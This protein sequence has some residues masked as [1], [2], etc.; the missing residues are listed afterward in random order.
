MAP[1]NLFD[2]TGIVALVTG[3]NGGLGRSMALG[4]ANAGAAV[5]IFGRNEK[6]NQAVLAELKAAG[7]RALALR[8]DMTKDSERDA[9]FAQVENTLGPVHVLVNNAGLGV[10]KPALAETR[11]GWLETLDVNLTSMFLMSKTAALSML[12]RKAGKIINIASMYSLFGSGAVPAY[13]ASK[14]A[15]VQLTKSLAIEFAPYHIQVN[16]IVP[17]F[18]ETE[19]TAPIKTM[20]LYQEVIHRTPAGRWGNPEECAGAAVFLAAAASDFVTGASLVVDGGYSIF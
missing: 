7:S 6:K 3:G 4:F 10:F 20:P 1:K 9:A 2:L 19:M 18:F 5:A 12:Q 14:G 17:G 8:V 16:A 15:V 13:S 11:E